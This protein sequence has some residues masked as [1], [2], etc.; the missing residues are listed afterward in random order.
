MRAGIRRAV[1]RSLQHAVEGTVHRKGTSAG[2]HAFDP[3]DHSEAG[4][5]GLELFGDG[6]A[7]V[8]GAFLAVVE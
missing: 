1:G 7:V 4:K 6:F 3:F 8:D 5:G 2:E